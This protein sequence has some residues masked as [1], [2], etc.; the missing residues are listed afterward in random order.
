MRNS[1]IRNV[2]DAIQQSLFFSALHHKGEH[3]VEL[4]SDHSQTSFFVSWLSLHQKTKK[5]LKQKKKRHSEQ[6]SGWVSSCLMFPAWSIWGA[7]WPGGSED[8]PRPAGITSPS[9]LNVFQHFSSIPRSACSLELPDAMRPSSAGAQLAHSRNLRL[10]W[11]GPGQPLEEC[12]RL[13]PY[14]CSP[15]D[16]RAWAAA[17]PDSYSRQSV[18][19]FHAS[20]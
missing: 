2:S 9:F 4:L 10:N 14:F 11:A 17:W 1:A 8:R 15:W 19:T 20:A 6:V 16:I 5:R 13:R 18:E 7:C 3:E 12:L